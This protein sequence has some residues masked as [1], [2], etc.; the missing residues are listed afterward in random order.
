MMSSQEEEAICLYG[1]QE[2]GDNPLHSQISKIKTL[3][4]PMI[5]IRRTWELCKTYDYHQQ[6]N[7]VFS[8]M[9]I[10][11]K[12]GGLWC[13]TNM[14]QFQWDLMFGMPTA[15]PHW[16]DIGMLLPPVLVC[17]LA[18]QHVPIMDTPI[19]SLIAQM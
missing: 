7:F 5:I 15:R 13:C 14:H 17:V 3:G 9:P 10:T 19:F 8:C 6:Y 1:I 16:C 11:T 18:H 4:M 2:F 12:W